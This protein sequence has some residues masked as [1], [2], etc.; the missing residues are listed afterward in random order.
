MF[1]NLIHLFL[2]TIVSPLGAEFKC[3]CFA[4]KQFACCNAVE[5]STGI[6]YESDLY[7]TDRC[8]DMMI[9]YYTNSTSSDH[10]NACFKRPTITHISHC[11]RERC[12]IPSNSQMDFDADSCEIYQKVPETNAISSGLL[13]TEES[14]KKVVKPITYF[15]LYACITHMIFMHK[16]PVLMKSIDFM[17][18]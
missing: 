1:T 6:V 8:T 10:L 14:C 5:Q 13:Q 11:T 15:Q 3:H 2:I 16:W 17:N 7:T 9:S 18:I 4:D 12:C